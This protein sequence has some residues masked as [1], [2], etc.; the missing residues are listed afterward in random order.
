MVA[1]DAIVFDLFHTLIDTEHVRPAGYDP[2]RL[3]ASAGGFGVDGFAEFWEDT[4]VERETSPIDPVELVDRYAREVSGPLSATQRAEVDDILGRYRDLVV[5]NPQPEAV[6][7]LERLTRRYRVGLLTNCDA[8]EV[9]AWPRSPLAPLFDAAVF[10]YQVGA[11]KPDPVTYVTVLAGLD[12]VPDRAAFVG[13]GASDELAGAQTAG[14]Q[15]VVHCNVFDQSNDLASEAEQQQRA[16]QAHV[17]VSSFEQ[18]EKALI[19]SQG[20]ALD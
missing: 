19:R 15:L 20:T 2:T 4:Y 1:I 13:N 6:A 17:T 9:R 3:I 14:F 18:L 5:L 11:L 7:L 16:S 12:V 8:R 10:S